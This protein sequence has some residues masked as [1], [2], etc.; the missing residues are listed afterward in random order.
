[1]AL[2]GIVG[3]YSKEL[4]TYGGRII[5]HEDRAEMAYLFPNDRIAEVRPGNELVMRLVDH[6]DMAAV[7]FPLN[8]K[9]F[10]RER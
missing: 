7:R 1:M 2:Y 9:D 5:T 6:P 10:R 3:K 4:L 8:R